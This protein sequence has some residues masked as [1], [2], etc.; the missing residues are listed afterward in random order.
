MA[1]GN[2]G[3]NPS[4]GARIF[5]LLIPTLYLGV[6]FG[7]VLLVR[8]D[9]AD[10]LG[11]PPETGALLLLSS[12]VAGLLELAAVL[13]T[14][15]KPH[16]RPQDAALRRRQRAPVLAPE[17]PEDLRPVAPAAESARAP[18]GPTPAAR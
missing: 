4:V 2:G 16:S 5:L 18:Q 8:K 17:L 10:R 13:A 15:G 1:S 9:V 11:L 14:C 7:V 3:G 12:L 6:L